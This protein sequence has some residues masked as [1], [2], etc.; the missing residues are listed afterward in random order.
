M[1][2]KFVYSYSIKIRAS[3]YNKLL[4]SIFCLLLVMEVCFLYKDAWRS[5]SQL[6]RGQ[7]NMANEAK[8]VHNLF[9]FWSV[10]CAMCSRL[11]LRI[12]SSLLTNASCRHCSLGCISLI[13]W[14]YLLDLLGLPGFRK[15]WWIRQAADH[16]TVTMTFFW[17]KFSFM[18][19]FG[20]SSQSSHWA[21]HCWLS[22]TIHFKK[23]CLFLIER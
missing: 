14:A 16:Q 11:L 17:C 10:A 4:E 7:V 2:N 6:V 5:V 18:K 13:C 8:L 22:Y 15:P 20:A 21:G 1:R 12:E 19:C 3:G 23:K 9:N